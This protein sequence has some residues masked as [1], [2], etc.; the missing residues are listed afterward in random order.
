MTVA[1]AKLVTRREGTRE[2]PPSRKREEL[3]GRALKGY[4][5]LATGYWL[6][7]FYVLRPDAPL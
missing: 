2:V 4:W 5:L 3:T 1:P 6:Q 7:V